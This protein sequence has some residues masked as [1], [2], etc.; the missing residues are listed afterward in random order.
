MDIEREIKELRKEIEK[1]N[2][3][4]YIEN[5]SDISDYE[6][7]KLV[8]KLSELE[9]QYP[10]YLDENS[11]TQSVGSSLKENKFKKVPHNSPMLSLSNTYNEKEILEY[12]ERVRKIL[13]RE[14]DLKYCLEV[15]LDGLSISL[16]YKD[17]VLV[18]GV[19]R[20]DGIVGE[21]VTENILEIKSIKKVLAQKIDIEIRGEIV[22][23]IEKFKEL[24]QERQKKGEEIFANPRNAASGTLRQLNSKVVSERGLD[25]YFYFLVDAKKYGF[26]SHKESINFLKNL[27]I[28]TT[29]IFEILENASQI[30]ERIEY[31]KT[32]REKLEYETDGLVIKVDNLNLWDEI[33]TTSKSPRWAIAYKF[34]A[35]QVTT[36]LIDV[37]WQVGRTGKL[38]PVA[39]LEEVELSGSKVKR[40][41]LHNISEINKKDIRVGDRVFIE[42]AAEIIP[43][44]VK[45]VKDVRNGS[46]KK[47]EEP[48]LCP[49]C[50]EKLIREKENIDI[51]CINENCPSKIQAEIEYF[52]SRD[53]LNIVGLGEKNIKKFLELGF[54][55]ELPDIFELKKYREELK[56]MEKMGEKSVNKLLDMIED[57]KETNYSRLI[58]SLGIPFI[59]KVISKILAKKTKNI[60]NLMKMNEEEL[61]NIDGIG[62]VA[63]KEIIKYFKNEKNL[64]LVKRLQ[65][66]GLKF[67]EEDDTNLVNEENIF[68]GK[69]F[70]VTG[71]L[72][73][74]TRD[75]IKEEIER[76]GG[77]NLNAVSKNLNYLI[78]GEKAGSKLKK[79]QE[80]ESIKI[81][82]EEEFIKMKSDL[83]K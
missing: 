60:E 25:A 28:K 43:Q 57:S 80:I 81:L 38:T 5:K 62:E 68:F 33:G 7:D 56:N 76:L 49:S 27:G 10:E 70:L 72:N 31:W 17:G 67:K 23:P 50:G 74:Y 61:I 69:T 40:A 53:A 45:S 13:N 63:A 6:Y 39:E 16:I 73:L 35:H 58:Y 46:E 21:D 11:P 30:S 54:I 1:H 9:K 36:K 47:I 82:S 18:K 22:L 34:P 65:E 48:I 24:N 20:G 79:A 77:K 44:V 8:E 29:D 12:T 64:K 42:K 26:S 51:K 37:T 4:Y 83:T 14:V 66:S 3:N 75:Q 71:T 59:G 15:K 78:V 32:E 2:R 19:T 52:V 41:S 55:K